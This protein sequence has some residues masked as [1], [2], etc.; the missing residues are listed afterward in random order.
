[1]GGVGGQS[2]GQARSYCFSWFVECLL[3]VLLWHWCF[4]FVLFCFVCCCTCISF[5]SSTSFQYVNVV[6][7]SRVSSVLSVFL[8]LLIY[9]GMF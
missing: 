9:C 5:A 3:G 6:Y 2:H 4:Y 8:I 7:N 1:M